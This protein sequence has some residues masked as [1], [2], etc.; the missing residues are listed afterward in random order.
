M[1]TTEK[2]YPQPMLP[3]GMVGRIIAW[4]MPLGHRPIYA[5]V[6][7]LLDLQ[8]EDDLLDVACGSGYFLK[9]YASHVNSIAG[10][11]YSEVMVDMATKRHRNRIAAGKAEIVHGEA[12][13]LPWDD[14]KFS[15]VTSM[16]SFIGF[17]KPL[18]SL[19]EMCRVLRPGGRAVI[20]IE[21]NAEDGV[22]H[23]KKVQQYGMGLWTGDEVRKMMEDA[24]FSEV[25]IKYAKGM[26]M[27]KMMLACG[28]K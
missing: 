24:G 27:P 12:S 16:G 2:R 28:S 14:N 5:R 19:R 11:D 3:R 25:S 6:V 20:S 21:W 8:P 10:L 7:E 15:V 13:Q 17:P 9:K 4:M 1:N 22:D 23:S 18:E 26:G